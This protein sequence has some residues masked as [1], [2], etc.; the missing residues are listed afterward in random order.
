MKTNKYSMSFSTGGL[1]HHESVRITRLY[2]DL[3]NWAKIRDTVVDKNILQT[4]TLASAKRISREIC[5]RLKLL[6]DDELRVLIEGSP[7]DQAYILWLAVCRRHR[8]V[9]EF[10]V[11]VLRE[12]FLT[13]QYELHYE[14]FDAFFNAKAA[15]SDEL[16]SI[17]DS[18]R[19]K[20][21]QV[22]FKIL[23]EA[24]LLSPENHII[25][26]ILSSEVF[27]AIENTSGKDFSVFPVAETDL[28]EWA[29]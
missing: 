29:K 26:V 27:K 1:F 10:A 28:K 18:T 11:E 14:D 12:K 16:E 20:L 24:G 13:L 8:F 15:W 6:S 22:L 2:F 19:K 9:Y 17:T 21:K 23:K 4:R 5:S 3:G 25:P 7:Q